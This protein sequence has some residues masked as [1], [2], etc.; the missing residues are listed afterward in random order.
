M[1]RLE[2]VRVSRA[3]ADQRRG[4]AGRIEPGVC[5]RL[6]DEA[7]DALAR[8]LHPAGD[9]ARR[10]GPLRARPRAAGASR[11]AGDARLARSA[12]RARRWPRRG[13]CSRDLARLTPRARITRTAARC[14]RLPLPPR[15]A[16]MVLDAGAR[17]EAKLAARNG[18][19]ADRARPR[20]RRR[21]SRATG[22]T[23]L[24]RDARRAR[25][26]A[27]ALARRWAVTR[28]TPRT[29]RSEPS[30]RSTPA[31]CWRWPI[32]TA[33]P[34]PRGK[35]GR[36]PAGQ[37]P[38]RRARAGDR[39]WRASRIWRWP[40][41]AARRQRASF[42]PRRSSLAEIEEP[43]PSAS[44]PR[45]AS[46]SIASAAPARR[47]GCGGSARI[48]LEEQP[49]AVEPDPR[50][51]RGCC[52][53]IAQLGSAPAVEQA[54]AQWRDRVMFLRARGGE[55]WPDLSDAALAAGGATGWRR[56]CDGRTRARRASA[57]SDLDAALNALLPWDLRRRLDAGADAF[58]GAERLAR[59][60]RLR[61]RGR[62]ASWRS[63]CRSCSASTATRR[64][65]AARCR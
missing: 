19:A 13:R 49:I 6:W 36:V 7:A 8:A 9:P 30:R 4:R 12:A 53:G 31:R 61:R 59:A 27:R 35:A 25:A 40:S 14:A 28:R 38:R 45:G 26:T 62:P 17:G 65:P 11:D 24:R 54:L 43:S 20:R 32:R 23:R 56:C 33:S 58:R 1:T 63:A 47:G 34:R 37:R 52:A 51:P 48:V 10:S 16:R 50:R 29:R 39:R 55:T 42:W 64:S 21:R 5:Y 22:S 46:T 18:G 44:K 57:P 41:S 15:L 3:A 2:T 60:D